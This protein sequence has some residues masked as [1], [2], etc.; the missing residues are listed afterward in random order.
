MCHLTRLR[1]WLCRYFCGPNARRTSAQAKQQRKRPRGDGGKGGKQSAS[2]TKVADEEDDSDDEA[3]SDEADD[4]DEDDEADD[5]KVSRQQKLAAAAGK[6][7]EPVGKGKEPIGKGTVK[8]ASKGGAGRSTKGG[9]PARG[10][11]GSARA[12]T[13]AKKKVREH[14]LARCAWLPCTDFGSMVEFC[15]ARLLAAVS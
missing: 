2:K 4:D 1:G 5:P 9:L 15:R 7:K 12:A 13:G 3:D 10:S 14:A 6:E 8:A 11:K